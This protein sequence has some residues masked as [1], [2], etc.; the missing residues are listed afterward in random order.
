[1]KTNPVHYCH[2]HEA[3]LKQ[4][5]LFFYRGVLGRGSEVA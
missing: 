5:L 1:M 3:E 2:I 4:D